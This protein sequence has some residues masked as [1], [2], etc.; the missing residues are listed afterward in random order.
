LLP[1]AFD[2]FLW[3]GPRLSLYKLIQPSLREMEHLALQNPTIAE[4]MTFFTEF[5]RQ[6][7]LFGI[8][9]TFPLGVFSLMSAN[10]SLTSPLGARAEVEVAGFL[11]FLFWLLG[12]TI[13]GWLLGILYFYFVAQV[14]AK[15]PFKPL[16]LGRSVWHGLLLSGFWSLAVLMI[17]LPLFL[18]MGVLFLI[19]PA[20]AS[21]AYL[22]IAF[23]AMWL[24]LPVFFSGHAIFADSQNF[25]RSIVRS[26]RM[27]RYALPSL[28]WF[29]LVSLIISQGLN[30]L[31]LVPPADSWMMLVGIFGHAFI[32]T[33]LLAASFIY[34]RDL[35][36]W[37][38]SALLWM[39]KRTNSVQA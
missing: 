1:I 27:M 15:E 32:S 4:N 8:L 35:N 12:L 36:A 23:L 17:S 30:F 38:E 19:N 22:I 18:L 39:K 7:N 6:V 34:Y 10:L 5:W 21:F 25:F 9:R 13:S 33:A 20:I 37:V 28:G 3:L 2:L 24:M 26:F 11:N 14:A 29:A 31:W 16:T